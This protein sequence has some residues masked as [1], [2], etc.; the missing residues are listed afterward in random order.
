MIKAT[1]TES[2]MKMN[3]VVQ[4]LKDA[5]MEL[6]GYIE[7]V[8]LLSRV[9]INERMEVHLGASA[10]HFRVMMLGPWSKHQRLT[11]LSRSALSPRAIASC[12]IPSQTPAGPPS[13][14]IHSRG[15]YPHRRRP[16]G[17]SGSWPCARTSCTESIGALPRRAS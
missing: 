6:Y 4:Y 5:E 13:L 17:R 3:Q 11:L 14:C 10:E 7:R 2:G 12:R 16:C 1:I 9:F 8:A 15:S